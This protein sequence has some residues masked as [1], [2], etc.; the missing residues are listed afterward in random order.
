MYVLTRDAF[1][2]GRLIICLITIAVLS[3]SCANSNLLPQGSG[4][5]ALTLSV[6]PAFL[7][8]HTA[9][10]RFLMPDTAVVNLRVAAES[11]PEIE[12]A[13]A[14]ATVVEDG[15]GNRS[16][17]AVLGPLPLGEPLL[18]T[19]E[20]P[21]GSVVISSASGT[22]NLDGSAAQQLTLRL[23]PTDEHP[24][25][26]E[27]VPGESIGTDIAVPA[28]DYRIV[29]S[30]LGSSFINRP[31]RFDWHLMEFNDFI[32]SAKDRVGNHQAVVPIDGG[33][34]G[35]DLAQTLGWRQYAI[36]QNNG[37]IDST[38]YGV[39]VPIQ[40][41]YDGNGHTE[42]TVPPASGWTYLGNEI[43]LTDASTFSRLGYTFSHWNS[44]PENRTVAESLPPGIAANITELNPTM[45]AQWTPDWIKLYGGAGL[46]IAGK[47]M[48]FDAGG[49]LFVS[50]YHYV[51][52]LPDFWVGQ[53]DTLEYSLMYQAHIDNAVGSELNFYLANT[54][55]NGV[56]AAGTYNNES[57]TRNGLVTNVMQA[58]LITGDGLMV[59][60]SDADSIHGLSALV[61]GN[62]LVHGSTKSYK[63]NVGNAD[64]M[65]A[66]VTNIPSYSVLAFAHYAADYA[67]GLTYEAGKSV[68]LANGNIV[69]GGCEING[70]SRDAFLLC[71]DPADGWSIKW[72]YYY[73]TTEWET[74]QSLGS[75]GLNTVYAIINPGY[76]ASTTGTTNQDMVLLQI[77]GENGSVNWQH[78][79]G[80]AYRDYGDG[81]VATETN[82]LVSGNSYSSSSVPGTVFTNFLM[83]F[84][85]S[86]E[87]LWQQKGPEGIM[88]AV[89]ELHD[90]NYYFYGTDV[91]APMWR[92]ALGSLPAVTLKT[93]YGSAGT[94]E[95][96]PGNL[97]ANIAGIV[98]GVDPYIDPEAPS[99]T[100]SN[101]TSYALSM[102]LPD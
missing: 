49:N 25:L 65:V 34:Y 43:P 99:Y 44:T 33:Y 18:V 31:F 15:E 83:M 40:L 72:Q 20:I 67:S 74:V 58:S 86:G 79:I 66:E 94:L 48:V 93:T 91:R 71:V 14:T 57:A 62:Y 23:L 27:V 6:D 59:G 102:L 3:V 8:G 39:K 56:L 60:G 26:V 51:A 10:S 77:N 81:L 2:P 41:Y 96:Q 4:R 70:T 97:Q 11:A 52:D 12:L 55:D 98:K 100:V 38:L 1:R 88:L 69:I 29:F 61:N 54:P 92:L 45:Y 36:L 78:R 63:V 64:I 35:L 50:A 53:F 7:G 42:G 37:S 101:A 5:L 30:D 84:D 82:V 17:S 76:T 89:K 87:L 22:V 90:A 75:D 47:D 95:V 13:S 46:K 80:G 73:R 32:F 68:Q 19:A 85:A 28:G 21:A 16:A 24:K 9:H